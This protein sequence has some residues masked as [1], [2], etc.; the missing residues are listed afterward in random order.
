MAFW[1]T[2]LKGFNV[3]KFVAKS[4]FAEQVQLKCFG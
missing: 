2:I 1:A 3:L 4:F